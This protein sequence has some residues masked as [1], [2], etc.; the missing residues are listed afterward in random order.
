[1]DAIEI[2]KRIK[3]RRKELNLTLEQLASALGFNKST[4]QRYEV[5]KIDRI[6]LPVLQSIAK[7]LRV[8]PNWLALKTDKQSTTVGERIRLRREELGM[9]VESLAEKTGKNRATIYRYEKDEI[10]NISAVTISPLAKALGTTPANLMGWEEP[11]TSKIQPLN[12]EIGTPY[13]P[14]IHDILIL[15]QIAAGLPLYAE[16]NIEGYT[17]TDRNGGADY[18]ALKVKGDSM[19]AAQINDGNLI[20]VRVQP[21]VENGE[22]AI[23]RVNNEEATVKRFKQEG[24]IVHLIPQSFNPEHQVQTYNLKDTKI[25]VIGKVVECRIEF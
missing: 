16:G 9:S 18:F 5:G 15:G 20:I 4:L 6:K 8:D 1:M 14:K 24:N 19:T 23:V 12:K 7:E 3:A 25:E 22:I 17:Y 2:G 10:E 13:N 21:T 11:D